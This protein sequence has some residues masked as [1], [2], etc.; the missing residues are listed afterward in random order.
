VLL[1]AGYRVIVYDRRGFG[2]SSH[3]TIGYDY[4]T[5]AADLAALMDKLDLRDTTLV[6]HAMG[7]GEVTRY[8]GAYGSARVA[9]AVLV[10]P[11]LPFLLQTSDNPEGLPSNLFD[12][13][14]ET[15]RADTPAWLTGFLDNAYNIDV[16]GG[17]L[18]STQAV[19]ASFNVAMAASAG[20]AIACIPTWTTDFRRD[21]ARIDVP[22]LVVQGDADRLLPLSITGQRLP[23]LL[24]AMEL[25]VI[26]GGP[27]AIMWTH[28]HRVNT[29]L[30]DFLHAGEPAHT[31]LTF[32]NMRR[33]SA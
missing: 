8:L 13:F 11:I 6:G 30:L 28:A 3:P 22:V 16:L 23:G 14:I 5:F 15:A 2:R 10:A 9:R 26:E 27:N 18:V 20:A 1:D 4:D 29:I 17:T 21:L 7:T 31:E 19:M 12:G 25:V 33:T 32:R 24:K